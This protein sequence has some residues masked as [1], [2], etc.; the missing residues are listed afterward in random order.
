LGHVLQGFFIAYSTTGPISECSNPSEYVYWDQIHPSAATHEIL[1][2]LIYDQVPAPAPL[3]LLLAGGLALGAW[4][5][6][7]LR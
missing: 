3:S 5:R 4:N 7:T 2:G 1:A 6:A